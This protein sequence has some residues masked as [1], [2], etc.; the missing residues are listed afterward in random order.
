V[1]RKAQSTIRT[2]LDR[3]D[4]STPTARALSGRPGAQ[5]FHRLLL[6]DGGRLL[7]HN[8]P[9]ATLIDEY[10]VDLR[11]AA[12]D[13]IRA[14]GRS[15]TA[16]T[17]GP[18]SYRIVEWRCAAPIPGLVL[19]IGAPT[20]RLVARTPEQRASSLLV[21][22]ASLEVIEADDSATALLGRS[23][24]DFFEGADHPAILAELTAMN[25]CQ[26]EIGPRR[27]RGGFGAGK[28]TLH[29]TE[30]IRAA[31]PML[32]VTMREAAG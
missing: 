21:H 15:V 11:S 6:D 24:L 14:R 26:S 13:A 25:E 12:R 22:A 17:R 10:Q 29:L 4:R 19:A 27:A 3:D 32:A 2:T 8:S 5:P 28:L 16:F 31:R 18:S 20:E 9:A 1:E 30:H 7:A 23:L